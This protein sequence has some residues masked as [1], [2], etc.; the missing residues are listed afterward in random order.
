MQ[1]DR[2]QNQWEETKM[3]ICEM[4]SCWIY[5]YIFVCVVGCYRVLCGEA[6]AEKECSGAVQPWELASLG[7][8]ARGTTR[9]N[10]HLQSHQIQLLFGAISQGEET[11]EFTFEL[12]RSKSGYTCMKRRLT[13]K[14]GKAVPNICNCTCTVMLTA[15]G[16]GTVFYSFNVYRGY[17]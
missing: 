2:I 5:I 13:D 12:L 14:Q 4:W 16:M 15:G 17:W 10:Y 6:R 7:E 1:I 3:Q 8:R 11:S 9:R